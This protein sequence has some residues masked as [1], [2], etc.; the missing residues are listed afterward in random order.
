MSCRII[1]RDIEFAIIDNVFEQIDSSKFDKLILKLIHTKK[2][3]VIN[4]FGEK[5]GLI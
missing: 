4:D 2:N 1:G 5:L 3:I